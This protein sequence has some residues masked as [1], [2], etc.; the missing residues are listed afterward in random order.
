[1]C[2]FQWQT[3]IASE[4]WLRWIRLGLIQAK[5]CRRSHGNAYF[6]RFATLASPQDGEQTL[7]LAPENVWAQPLLDLTVIV[8]DHNH[9][10]S[11]DYESKREK[12]LRDPL[13]SAIRAALKTQPACDNI[14]TPCKRQLKRWKRELKDG[15]SVRPIKHSVLHMLQTL[16]EVHA[17]L[18]PPDE[19]D[20]EDS[21]DSDEEE[22]EERTDPDSD[23]EEEEE[24]PLPEVSSLQP[25]LPH[26]T[27][28]VPLA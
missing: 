28:V 7:T 1:M 21:F 26:C 20:D 23:Q 4:S 27:I 17:A 15:N 12:D 19:E 10:K 6:S 18:H 9:G 22:E 24:E 11:L 5:R 8:D 2:S 16:E 14:P 25:A 3:H 13:K